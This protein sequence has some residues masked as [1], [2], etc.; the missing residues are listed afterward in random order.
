MVAL[1]ESLLGETLPAFG[2]V[3]GLS[4]LQRNIEV[5]A[6]DRKIETRVFVLDKVQRDLVFKSSMLTT[7]HCGPGNLPQGN[8]SAADKQ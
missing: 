5:A 3:N 2:P 1:L 7:L 8:P 6:F 4:C